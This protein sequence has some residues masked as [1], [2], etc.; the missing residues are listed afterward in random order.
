[1]I[2]TNSLEFTWSWNLLARESLMSF[3]VSSQNIFSA[4]F[5]SDWCTFT[6]RFNVFLN[7]REV[8]HWLL[9]ISFVLTKGKFVSFIDILN[10][11][12]AT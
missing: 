11:I 5:A 9:Y 10:V 6:A 3:N 8:Q 2:A 7:K 12:L 4:V 1:M